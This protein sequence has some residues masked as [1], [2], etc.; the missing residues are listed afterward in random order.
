MY[1]LLCPLHIHSA[2]W[3]QRIRSHASVVQVL[4]TMTRIR[5]ELE[6]R[7]YCEL[8]TATWYN[9]NSFAKLGWYV[10]QR[11]TTLDLSWLSFKNGKVVRG[12]FCSMRVACWRG[13]SPKRVGYLSCCQLLS[14]EAQNDRLD[15]SLVSLSKD[16][17]ALVGAQSDCRYP[18]VARRHIKV[19]KWE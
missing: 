10:C 7:T 14:K 16:G 4:A 6:G 2:L 9:G 5:K 3:M 19:H 15:R 11:K 1:R 12:S 8:L 17:R 18:G 13:N